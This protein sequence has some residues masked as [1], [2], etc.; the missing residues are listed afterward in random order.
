MK[1]KTKTKKPCL[2]LQVY[3]AGTKNSASKRNRAIQGTQKR[4]FHWILNSLSVK[5]NQCAKKVM[6]YSLRLVDFTIGLVNYVLNLPD[7]QVMF[8]R[9]FKLQMNGKQF[10]S[11]KNS[12]GLVQ[13]NLGLV[14]AIV[15]N[16]S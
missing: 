11:S 10:V 12:W 9:E 1:T 13:M 6:S 2:S 15:V 3:L 7:G 8:L 5:K 14:Y 4:N 16:G